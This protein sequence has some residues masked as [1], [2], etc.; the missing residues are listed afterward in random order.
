MMRKNRMNKK[1]R[2]TKTETKTAP[3]RFSSQMCARRKQ[4]QTNQGE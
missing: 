2:N 3:M 4:L 1:N